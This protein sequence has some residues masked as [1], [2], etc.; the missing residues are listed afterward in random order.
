MLNRLKQ[1]KVIW[2]TVLTEWLNVIFRWL[3]VTAAMAWI[4]SSFTSYAW[5]THAS[6]ASSSRRAFIGEA[7]HR[8][9]FELLAEN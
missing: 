7:W 1:V 6:P 9:L 5:T 3:H 4:G 2:L 8:Q